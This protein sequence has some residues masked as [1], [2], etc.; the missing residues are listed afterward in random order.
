MMIGD[1]STSNALGTAYN[2]AMIAIAN[3][4]QI[5]YMEQ[6]SDDYFKGGNHYYR[7]KSAGG[8][9][10]PYA[11]CGMELAIERLFNKC[12]A[13]NKAYFMYYTGVPQST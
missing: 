5:P 10:A 4:Y 6:M 8:H 12:V 11:Y 1:Y 3:H 7:E 9:P 13:D 2:N